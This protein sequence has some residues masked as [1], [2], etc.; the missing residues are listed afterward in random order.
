MGANIRSL[1]TGTRGCSRE[2]EALPIRENG[3]EREEVVGHG[4]LIIIPRGVEHFPFADEETHVM[5]LEPKTALNT[6]NVQ[7]QA[8]GRRTRTDLSNPRRR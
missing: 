2:G 5:L 3:A 8:H 4:E 1:A 7:N 6:G